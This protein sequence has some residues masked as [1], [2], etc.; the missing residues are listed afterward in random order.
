E[1]DNPGADEYGDQ[2]IHRLFPADM[3]GGQGDDGEVE[4]HK[5]ASD[6]PI[7]VFLSQTGDNVHPSGG[8]AAAQDEAEPYTYQHA[9]IEGSEE[10]VTGQWIPPSL[11]QPQKKGNGVGVD[12]GVDQGLFAKHP[13]TDK[14][15][16]DVQNKNHQS[17]GEAEQVVG[18]QGDPRKPALSQ[19]VRDR[20]IVDAQ[21]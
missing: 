20:E 13:V 16:G 21:G 8:S 4:D 19:F 9:G 6:A 17:R 5:G 11:G 15:E 14:I 1:V 12:N 2:R 3:K 7:Q 18:Q 10:R